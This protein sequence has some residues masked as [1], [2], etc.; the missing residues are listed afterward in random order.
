M[1]GAKSISSS[2]PNLMGFLAHCLP[3]NTFNKGLAVNN[4]QLYKHK[5]TFN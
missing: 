2:F 5:E 4:C 3:A 1:F